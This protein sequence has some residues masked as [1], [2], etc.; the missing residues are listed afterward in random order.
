MLPHRLKRPRIDKSALTLGAPRRLRDRKYLDSF[1]HAAC[2]CCGVADRTVVG[3]HIRT[4]HEGGIGLK[5]P[6]DLVLPLCG[7]CH[8]DQEASPGAVWWIERVLKPLARKRYEAW[9]AGRM[10]GAA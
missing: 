6:D 4:G 8:A 5:P 9:K 1:Q 2:C 3:A 7:T 10:K